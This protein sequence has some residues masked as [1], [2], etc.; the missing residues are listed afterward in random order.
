MSLGD[1]S[2]P[3]PGKTQQVEA[4]DQEGTPYTHLGYPFKGKLTH[5][6]SLKIL[7]STPITWVCSLPSLNKS[8]LY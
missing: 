5:Y 3:L 7:P 2:G 6:A 8:D 1:L 4:G